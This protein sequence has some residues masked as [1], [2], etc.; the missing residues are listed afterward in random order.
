MPSRPCVFLMYHELELP[1]R[2][3]CQPEPGYVRY[4]LPLEMFRRQMAWLKDSRWQGLNVT[5][6]LHYPDEP[7]VCIT[8]DDGSETDL[9]A[10]AP[11]LREFGFHATFYV[12]S[13][14]LGMPGYLTA[15]QMRE[16]DSEEFEIGCHSM[17]HPYLSD[18]SEPDL[19]REILDAKNQIEQILGHAIQHF[20]CPGGR[21]D[22]RTLAMARQAGFATVANS[23]YRAN[24][25]ATSLYKLGRVG[26]LRHDS[27]DDFTAS[28]HGHGLWKKRLPHQTRH[29]IQQLLGNRTYDR[30][31]GVLLGK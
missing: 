18:L 12:T 28:C 19:K 20:S 2:Q 11:L 5:E 13:G 17:T 4:V 31:R 15:E 6:A 22:Q 27:F 1:G 26:V 14:R 21:Y 3:L 30:I 8:F 16:L 29:G 9:I 24:S 25:S 7:G 23:D 10:A